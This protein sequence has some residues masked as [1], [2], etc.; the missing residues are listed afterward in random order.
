MNLENTLIIGAMHHKTGTVLLN[1]VLRI[2]IP[3]YFKE[4]KGNVKGNGKGRPPT[5]TIDFSNN[6]NCEPHYIHFPHSKFGNFKDVCPNFKGIHIIRNPFEIIT[7]AYNY[8]KV[9]NE[10]WVLGTY[11]QT[12]NTLSRDEGL[13][14]EIN[15][16]GGNVIRNMV[17][18]DYTDKRILTVSIE[19]FYCNFDKTI[20]TIANFLGYDEHECIKSC[21]SLDKNRNRKLKDRSSHITNKSNDKYRYNKFLKKA[22]KQQV[23]KIVEKYQSC[24]FMDKF[25]Y[26]D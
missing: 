16:I 15:E 2:I 1:R 22:H 14:Y 23:I 21:R 9:C 4:V 10:P 12:V 5:G 7:S 19:D 13:M 25:G 6:I 8:H 26:I 18:F 20:S 11:Q 3:P 17:S 24:N